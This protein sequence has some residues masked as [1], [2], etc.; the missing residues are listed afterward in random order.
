MQTLFFFLMTMVNS[1]W[2]NIFYLLSGVILSR[3]GHPDKLKMKWFF[4]IGITHFEQKVIE[5][6]KLQKLPSMMCV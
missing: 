6:M 4:F 2:I 1:F 3:C 5:S